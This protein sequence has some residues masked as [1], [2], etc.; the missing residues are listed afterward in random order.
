MSVRVDQDS[1]IVLRGMLDQV[2]RATG[3]ERVAALS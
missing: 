2:R 1:L 3:T